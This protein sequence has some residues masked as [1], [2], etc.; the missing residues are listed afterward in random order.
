[1]INY[2]YLEYSFQDDPKELH[3]EDDRGVW[4]ISDKMKHAGKQSIYTIKTIY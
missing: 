3:V 2:N 4:A 1:M